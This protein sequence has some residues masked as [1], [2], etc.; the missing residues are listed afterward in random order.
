MTPARAATA[1]P[2]LSV[3]TN[4]PPPHSEVVWETDSADL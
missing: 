3:A 2:V 4:I 1:H